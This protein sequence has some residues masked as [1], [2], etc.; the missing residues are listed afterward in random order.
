ML[1]GG[2]GGE[3]RLLCEASL[4]GERSPG[5]RPGEW[6]TLQQEGLGAEM[7]RDSWALGGSSAPGESQAL[8]L[9]REKPLK[10]G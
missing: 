3:Q 1:Q 8:L 10:M 4:G 6:A 9:Q 2:D 7:K 5:Q